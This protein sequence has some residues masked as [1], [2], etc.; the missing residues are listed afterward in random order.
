MT[1]EP[2][3]NKLRLREI[4]QTL[5]ADLHAALDRVRHATNEEDRTRAAEA[6]LR[7]LQRFTDFA[8]KG[9]VPDDLSNRGSC[10]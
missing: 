6:H 8:A 2:V 5:A 7:A 3:S 4:E 1:P 9:I 10:E